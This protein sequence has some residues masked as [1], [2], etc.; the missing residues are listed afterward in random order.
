[1][2][3]GSRVPFPLDQD[4]VVRDS[5]CALSADAEVPAQVRTASFVSVDARLP[6]VVTEA[7]SLAHPSASTVSASAPLRWPLAEAQAPPTAASTRP[8]M[9]FV[10]PPVAGPSAP[11]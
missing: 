6:L 7:L 11:E 3:F 5:G 1:M 8:R 4:Y 9:R 2:P 10:D